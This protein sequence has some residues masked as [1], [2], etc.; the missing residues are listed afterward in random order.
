MEFLTGSLC[1]N[2]GSLVSNRNFST[3]IAVKRKL[4]IMMWCEV[5]DDSVVVMKFRPMKA[6]NS[7]EVKIETTLNLFEGLL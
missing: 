6:G 4:K 2:R 5:A 1:N 7:V 3:D